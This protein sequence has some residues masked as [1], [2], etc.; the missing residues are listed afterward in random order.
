MVW[1]H[2][3]SGEPHRCQVVLP[4]EGGRWAFLCQAGPAVRWADILTGSPVQVDGFVCSPNI[5]IKKS[6]AVTV[7]SPLEVDQWCEI[8]YRPIHM[9]GLGA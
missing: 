1:G 7:H 3:G 5:I 9:M 2:T 8:L 6:N 4:A